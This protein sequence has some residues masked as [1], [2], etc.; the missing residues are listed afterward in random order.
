VTFADGTVETYDVLILA[1]G[2]TARKLALPGADRP[3]CWSFA[4]STTRNG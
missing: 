1:T 2:S 3:T 4:P